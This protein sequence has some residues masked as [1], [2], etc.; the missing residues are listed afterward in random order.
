MMSMGE[1][2]HAPDT[3]SV[4]LAQLDLQN[5]ELNRMKHENIVSMHAEEEA[6]YEKMQTEISISL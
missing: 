2:V 6:N 1:T 3:Q 5:F 4:A